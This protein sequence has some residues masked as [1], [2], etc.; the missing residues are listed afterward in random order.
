[1]KEI[2][3]YIESYLGIGGND[4][5]PIAALFQSTQLQ[6]HDYLLK[7]GQY[8]QS[9]SFIKTGYLRIFAPD[10]NGDKDITQWISTQ[11]MFVTDL[12]SFV[13]GTPARWNIQ[14][15]SDCELYTIS[16]EKY[17]RIGDY[18]EHWAELDKLFIAKCFVTLENRVFSQLSMTAEEKVRQLLA[19]NSE[20]FLQVPLQYIASMLGMTPETLS[21]VRRKMVS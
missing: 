11:G 15:L 10:S 1:M 8:T 18:V 17:D 6:K 3:K 9:I 7:L 5:S 4:L 14:A 13:F 21:R 2:E 12:S 20:I 16:K 19:I